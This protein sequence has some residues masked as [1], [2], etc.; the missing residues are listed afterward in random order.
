MKVEPKV[1]VYDPGAPSVSGP[2][3][4][5]TVGAAGPTGSTSSPQPSSYESPGIERRHQPS[6][7]LASLEAL[8]R[9]QSAQAVGSGSQ[10]LRVSDFVH[11]AAPPPSADRATG[12]Q[13]SGPAHPNS[14]DYADNFD[15]A[16]YDPTTDSIYASYEGPGV[17]V[18][19]PL[20]DIAAQ[21]GTPAQDAAAIEAAS[22]R[23]GVWAPA[24][25]N[26][27]TTPRL[28]KL[29]HDARDWNL[30]WQNADAMTRA[31]LELL[32]IVTA[33][34]GNGQ[35][36]PGRILAGAAAK[37]GAR[38]AA[39]SLT[40]EL[41]SVAEGPAAARIV[42][43]EASSVAP[44]IGVAATKTE[45]VVAKTEAAAARAVPTLTPGPGG[46]MLGEAIDVVKQ[47]PPSERA[48]LMEELVQQV[49]AKATGG[50]WKASRMPGANGSSVWLGE[51]HSMVIDAQGNIFKG[52]NHGL[53]FGLVNG[54][55]GLTAWSS[56][57]Q[58]L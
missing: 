57:T 33:H 7:P 25:M 47:A 24:A 40:K 17:V 53:A 35:P 51:T 54:K 26:R 21:P 36:K 8:W 10:G 43:K 1:H 50:P 38:R 58:V 31:S 16:W 34:G 56:L 4:P 6:V 14:P 32:P 19:Y 22:K 20:N 42:R 27:H 11:G 30:A 15:E 18:R 45:A 37:V 49:E 12:R 5:K 13:M 3:P 39:A 46:K 44:N 48:K 41:G 2:Q 9:S 23:D 52:N 28:A 55:L 29:A